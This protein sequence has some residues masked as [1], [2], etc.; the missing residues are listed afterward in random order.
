MKSHWQA[1]RVGN[2]IKCLFIFHISCF[3]FAAYSLLLCS[4]LPPA[5]H[6]LAFSLSFLFQSLLTSPLPPTSHPPNICVKSL[7][8]PQPGSVGHIRTRFPLF[9]LQKES[10]SPARW[11]KDELLS[12]PLATLCV[13]S[14][15][16][17]WT[18]ANDAV[19][20]GDD[21]NMLPHRLNISAH[22]NPCL[23]GELGRRVGGHIKTSDWSKILNIS[24]EE[25]QSASWPLLGSLGP[26]SWERNPHIIKALCFIQFPC[27]DEFL[28]PMRRN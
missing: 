8:M 7:S 1:D 19:V 9:F 26:I 14:L 11:S 21:I 6:F 15:S 2:I 5:I 28:L 16:S 10:S 13:S 24:N 18:A 4:I 12:P 22:I 25:F 17:S 27:R 3:A 20:A 23:P